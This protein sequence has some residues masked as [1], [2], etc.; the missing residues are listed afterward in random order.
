MLLAIHFL[1]IIQLIASE[2]FYSDL[3]DQILTKRC[4]LKQLNIVLE[5][6]NTELHRLHYGLHNY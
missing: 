6:V 1:A 3:N 4:F 2:R 5:E